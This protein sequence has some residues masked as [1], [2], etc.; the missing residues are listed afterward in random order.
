MITAARI[1]L[2]ME[3]FETNAKKNER[4]YQDS[5]ETK[6]LSI[7]RRYAEQAEVYA[8]AYKALTQKKEKSY[9]ID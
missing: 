4:Y 2:Q 9:T 6:Y 8:I 5:G 7:A 3:R 1:K